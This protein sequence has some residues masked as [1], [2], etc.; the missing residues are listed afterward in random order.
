MAAADKRAK[1][2]AMAAFLKAHKVVRR[3]A[4]DP[5]TYGMVTLPYSGPNHLGM[6]G[7]A[8]YRRS[9]PTPASIRRAGNDNSN[10]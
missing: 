5:M 3:T 9:R 2:K 7:S 6:V 10:R 1:D 8:A 4:R